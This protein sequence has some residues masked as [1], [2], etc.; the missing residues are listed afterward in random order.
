MTAKVSQPGKQV[1]TKV[2][3]NPFSKFHR[4][5]MPITANCNLKGTL[6]GLSLIL[7]LTKSEKLKTKGNYYQCV[8]LVFKIVRT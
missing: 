7:A 6:Y 5:K 8:T 3:V 4:Q 2:T 1:Q